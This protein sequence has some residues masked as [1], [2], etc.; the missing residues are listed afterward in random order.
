MARGM[1]AMNKVIAGQTDVLD[2]MYRDDVGAISFFWGVPGRGEKFKKGS[3]ISHVIAKRN[4][5]GEDGE[6]VARKIVE[7]LAYGKANRRYNVGIESQE[8]VDIVYDGY[9]AHL[10]LYKHGTRQ[11]WVITGYSP[12]ES[13]SPRCNRREI[14]LNRSYALRAYTITAGRGSGGN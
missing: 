6:A 5:K 2:A 9:L 11:T 10:A 12:T 14:W 7:V 4:A 8:R 1:A 13:K 3:G